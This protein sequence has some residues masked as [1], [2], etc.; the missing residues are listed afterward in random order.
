MESHVKDQDVEWHPS[1][2]GSMHSKVHHY[3]QEQQALQFVH[4]KKPPY[5]DLKKCN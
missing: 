3:M 2:T 4:H 5:T 1:T